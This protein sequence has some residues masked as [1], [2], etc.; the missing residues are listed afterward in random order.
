MAGLHSL[1]GTSCTLLG[2]AG[3]SVRDTMQLMRHTSERLTLEMY[4]DE[5]LLDVPGSVAHVPHL[6]TKTG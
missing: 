1:R 4:T 6:G 2:R 5:N 3:G